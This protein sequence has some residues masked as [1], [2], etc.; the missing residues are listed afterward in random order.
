MCSLKRKEKILL[1]VITKTSAPGRESDML[2][3]NALQL[4]EET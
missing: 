4:N 3:C 2:P 1:M